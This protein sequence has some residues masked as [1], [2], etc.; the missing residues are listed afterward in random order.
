MATPAAFSRL[1]LAAALLEYDNDPD[2]PDAPY[3]SAQNSAIFAHFRRNPAARPGLSSRKSDYLGVALPS[4]TASL[5]GMDSVLDNRRSRASKASFDALR[6]PFGL[7]G[8]SELETNEVE[9]EEVPEVD[10]A[11]WGLDAFVPKDKKI[12]QS[13]GKTACCWFHSISNTINKP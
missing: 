13:K 2:N 3:V 10:L 5:G 4:E 11:S 12:S 1:Q 6:N 8:Q 7:D 9:E